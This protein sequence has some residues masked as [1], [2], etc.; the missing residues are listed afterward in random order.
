MCLHVS[1]GSVHP[2]LNVAVQI[3][4]H[5]LVG[6]SRSSVQSTAAASDPS[7]VLKQK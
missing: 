6:W 1:H 5:G 4:A 3:W 7:F 2:C